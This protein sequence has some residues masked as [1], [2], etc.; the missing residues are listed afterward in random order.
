MRLTAASLL[1]HEHTHSWLWSSSKILDVLCALGEALESLIT[2]SKVGF[3][4][5]AELSPLLPW[6]TRPEKDLRPGN[7]Q[8]R[9]KAHGISLPWLKQQLVYGI[10]TKAKETILHQG[11][12]CH[13][14]HD[15]NIFP[16]VIVTCAWVLVR[17]CW[18]TLAINPLLDMTIS[19]W[20]KPSVLWRQEKIPNHQYNHICSQKNFI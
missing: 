14:L 17:S 15:L 4:S 12:Q 5:L 18:C 2:I 7:L 3:N 10:F 8:T 9:I 20:N 16:G 1:H 19:W 6:M 11:I 13:S